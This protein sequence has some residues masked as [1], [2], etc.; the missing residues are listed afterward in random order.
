MKDNTRTAWRPRDIFIA[1]SLVVFAWQMSTLHVAVIGGQ[2]PGAESPRIKTLQDRFLHNGI[3]EIKAFWRE[4][5]ER[6]VPLVESLPGDE[7]H[8]LVTFLWRGQED[9]RHVLIVG[10]V[11][12]RWAYSKD[13]A[14]QKL[15][16]RLPGTDVWYKTYRV[17]SDARVT[18]LLSP[19]DP[20]VEDKFANFPS[21]TIPCHPAPTDSS[22]TVRLHIH[23]NQPLR[24][25]F[26][27][28]ASNRRE[29]AQCDSDSAPGQSR[30]AKLI[31]YN[32]GLPA[33]IDS[34]L[35]R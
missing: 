23:D 16:A 11:V 3:Q 19:N 2:A 30:S 14:E 28:K 25:A 5:T 26:N 32:F 22:P 18:Y 29:S 34:S 7:R 17:R 33:F 20:L 4:V 10:G 6:G 12:P 9:T 31:F 35:V 13:S 8:R 1:V 15:M 27:D 24:N 21:A